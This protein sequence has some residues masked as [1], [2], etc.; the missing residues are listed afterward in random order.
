MAFLN[1]ISSSYKKIVAHHEWME[2]FTLFCHLSVG[3]SLIQTFFLFSG[4]VRHL[5]PLTPSSSPITCPTDLFS[6]SCTRALVSSLNDSTGCACSSTR[7]HSSPPVPPS[8]ALVVDQSQAVRFALDIASGM[9]FLHTLEP[10]VSRLYLN[11]KHVMV[12]AGYS[13]PWLPLGGNQP[14][15][16]VVD[17]LSFSFLLT[18]AFCYTSHKHGK[19]GKN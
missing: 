13:H 15:S 14:T 19:S 2:L 9:A 5:H 16:L 10:M 8:S 4:P 7:F 1:S 12:R 3:S 18:W 11:S 6:T 17:V